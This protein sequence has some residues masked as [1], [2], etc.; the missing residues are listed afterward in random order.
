M[1]ILYDREKAI[2]R[3]LSR[4]VLWQKKRITVDTSAAHLYTAHPYRP[5]HTHTA[6]AAFPCAPAGM[7]M[8]EPGKLT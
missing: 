4:F 3:K 6:N 8:Y 7:P 5:P 1:I 2:K